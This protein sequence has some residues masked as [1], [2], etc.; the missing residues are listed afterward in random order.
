MRYNQATGL[1]IQQ[2]PECYNVTPAS[3]RHAI[4]AGPGYWPTSR[5]V[6]S[7]VSLCAQFTYV[8]NLL[9]RMDGTTGSR[10]Q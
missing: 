8:I 4:H 9:I 7:L 3:S 5:S 10:E 2:T 6:N 1:L